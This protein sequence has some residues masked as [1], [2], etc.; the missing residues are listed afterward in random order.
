M[1]IL[2]SLKKTCSNN[3]DSG[4]DDEE[5]IEFVD[6]KTLAYHKMMETN[7]NKISLSSNKD[8][9]GDKGAAFLEAE[10]DEEINIDD[11]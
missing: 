4:D 10:S 7:A 1:W 2:K 5:T 3:D 6:E 11:I 9:T 8:K